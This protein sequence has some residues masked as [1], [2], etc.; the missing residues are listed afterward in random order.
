MCFSDPARLTEEAIDAL[1]DKPAVYKAF[2]PNGQWPNGIPR[3]LG[4]DEERILFFGKTGRL[5]GRLN[6]L[7][8]SIDRG[9]GPHVEGNL[10]HLLYHQ[11]ERFEIRQV[12][13]SYK[14]RDTEE[15]AT[16]EEERLIKKYVQRFGEVP[17]INTVIPNRYGDW[18]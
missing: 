5:R 14:D 12:M 3:L 16:A 11:A 17:P 7:L 6:D 4:I 1:D 9:D 18:P 8:T 10:I 13:F 15:A 2:P